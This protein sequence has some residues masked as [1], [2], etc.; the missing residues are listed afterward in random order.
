MSDTPTEHERLTVAGPFDRDDRTTVV[1]YGRLISRDMRAHWPAGRP[2]WAAINRLQMRNY[3]ILKQ[4]IEFIRKY[5]SGTGN[6]SYVFIMA[7]GDWYYLVDDFGAL[8]HL[9]YVSL[10]TV[11]SRSSL[12]S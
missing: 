4:H 1:R 7:N 11:R 10:N 8:N 6:P 3:R 9:A 5:T 12:F 2:N